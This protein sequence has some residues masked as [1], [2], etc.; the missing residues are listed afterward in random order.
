MIGEIPVTA[1]LEYEEHQQVLALFQQRAR[2]HVHLD[3]KGLEAWLADPSLHCWVSRENGRV[4]SLL[5]ATVYL[6]P[7]GQG[8]G[9]AWL[10][11]ILPAA[12]FGTDPSLE[13]LWQALSQDLTQAGVNEVALLEL[14]PWV[15]SLGS[16]WGFRRTNAIVTMRREDGD[17]PP[18]P[19]LPLRIRE[20]MP[21]D[22]ERVA[23]VDAAAFE[24]IWRYDLATLEA[25]YPHAVTFTLL[26]R[27]DEALG[28]QLST[29]HGSLGHLTRLAVVPQA[30]GQG[31]GGLLIGEML[32]YFA[33]L[34]I[35]T[36]TVNTQE[37]NERSQRLYKRLGFEFVGSG[38]PVWTLRLQ[39]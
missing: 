36:I 11:L 18:A 12:P 7:A 8:D 9:I 22:L 34:G 32:R 23:E 26:E 38:V 10:R 29:Q 15:A 17:I 30:Q 13:A 2:Q 35:T 4:Q 28:Y 25:A 24:P 19:T 27:E 6:P 33:R 14:D 31:L 3:W 20:V 21:S 37:D 5:G 39:G 1:R 16:R